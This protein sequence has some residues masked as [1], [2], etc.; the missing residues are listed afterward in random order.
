MLNENVVTNYLM[1]N[2]KKVYYLESDKYRSVKPTEEPILSK[3]PTEDELLAKE[4]WDNWINFTSK[5]GFNEYRNGRVPALIYYE[6]GEVK[7]YLIYRNDVVEENLITQS[8]YEELIG[9]SKTDEELMSYHNQKA[10]EFLN[11]YC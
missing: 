9:Q 10:L 7:D 3:E 6:N 8:F 1:E 5:Y 4:N 2:N 11:K